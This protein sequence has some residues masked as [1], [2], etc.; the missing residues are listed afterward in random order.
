MATWGSAGDNILL[1]PCRFEHTFTH[2]VFAAAGGP[3]AAIADL[4]NIPA[5]ILGATI[6]EL[7]LTDSDRGA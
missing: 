6:Y 5:V 7:F 4:V 3:Y 1:Q 2:H